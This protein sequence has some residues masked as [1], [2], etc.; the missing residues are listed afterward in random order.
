MIRK[1]RI[2]CGYTQSEL[3]EKLGIKQTT[4]AMWENGT[5]KPRSNMLPRIARALNCTIDELFADTDECDME[6]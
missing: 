3:A 6:V 1:Y 5:N 4:V 2:A